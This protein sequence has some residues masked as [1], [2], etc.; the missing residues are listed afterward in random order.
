MKDITFTFIMTALNEENNVKDAIHNTLNALNQYKIKGDVIVINDGSKDKTKE[1]IAE[2]MKKDKRITTID[3][4]KPHGVGASF[5][6]GVKNAKGD[7]VCCIPGDNEND[8][9]EVL[10]YFYLC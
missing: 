4:E 10:R 5:W 7:I 6:D 8:P 3:H 9:K 2:Y 1:I